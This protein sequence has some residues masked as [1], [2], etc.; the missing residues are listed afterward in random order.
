MYSSSSRAGLVCGLVLADRK[1]LMILGVFAEV[2]R[3]LKWSS[4]S[5]SQETKYNT[6]LFFV[7]LTS[8]NLLMFIPYSMLNDQQC[9][10]LLTII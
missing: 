4:S 7:R 9:L 2:G 5:F 1:K 10:N 8:L 6:T 3:F